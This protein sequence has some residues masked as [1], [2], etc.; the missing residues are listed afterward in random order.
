M[1]ERASRG[2]P[3]MTLTGAAGTARQRAA[4][5]AFLVLA[6]WALGVLVFASQWYA[7]DATRRAAS[8]YVYYLGWSCLMWA[9]AP[10]VLWFVRRHPIEPS[11]W[12]RTLAL[13]VAASIVLSALQ[14]LI[15][16]S[17]GWLRLASSSA[18]D[19]SSALAVVAVISSS[20]REV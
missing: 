15:E 12:K 11:T 13:H 7:Y 16:A 4:R 14:V 8:P 20:L 10:L 2:Q 19:H 6:G 18:F 5:K 17:L 9:L 1:N 3:S